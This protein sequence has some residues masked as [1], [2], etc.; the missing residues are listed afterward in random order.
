MV[1]SGSHEGWRPAAPPREPV[2]VRSQFIK[3]RTDGTRQPSQ[4]L[5]R[6]H[7][8]LGAKSNLLILE[9]NTLL[10]VGGLEGD[11]HVSCAERKVPLL[12]ACLSKCTDRNT[13]TKAA[14]ILR[15]VCL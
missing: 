7:G 8:T 1:P 6:K 9:I 5:R 11:K 13:S 15:W 4:L 10:F 3:T 2:R 12:T 14:V